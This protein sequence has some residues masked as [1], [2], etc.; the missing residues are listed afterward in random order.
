MNI[1]G[2]LSVIL[3]TGSPAIVL[4]KHNTK[5]KS[6][7]AKAYLVFLC[8]LMYIIISCRAF[9]VGTD[10]FGYVLSFLAIN[11]SNGIVFSSRD[12]G[13]SILNYLLRLFTKDG[14]V[15]LFLVS[16]PLPLSFYLLLK[17]EDFSLIHIY[18]AF[19]VLLDLEIFAFAMAG[20]RQ[21]LAIFFTVLAYKQLSKERKLPFFVFVAIA[22]SFHLSSIVFLAIYPL[23]NRKI[24]LKDFLIL[25]IIV[26]LVLLN[27]SLV[28]YILTDNP[29]SKVYGQYGVTY[30]T[31]GSLSMLVIQCLLFIPV[32]LLSPSSV[33]YNSSFLIITNMIWLGMIFQSCTPIIAEMFRMAFYYS[34][35]MCVFIP[36]A[37]NSWSDK[38]NRRIVSILLFAFSMIYMIV[39]NNPLNDY[40]FGF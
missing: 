31:T 32:F 23:R 3:L 38:S 6:R 2:L 40:S 16:W 24:K 12:F 34:I 8:L 14:H 26:I 22:C 13:F 11:P 33:K 29:I 10:T 17:D 18:L 28:L 30:M 37:I 19:L 5:G 20:I 7:Y 9:S 39:F 25:G 36:K 1:I 35:Y 4:D 27:P 21:T 15:Y